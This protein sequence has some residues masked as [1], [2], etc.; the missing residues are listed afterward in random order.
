MT[1]D[2]GAD[3][4][5]VVGLA[6]RLL[7]SLHPEGPMSV[8]LLLGR[9][10][11]SLALEVPLP[12]DARLLGSALH[13]QRGRPTQMQALFDAWRDPQEGGAAYARQLAVSGWNPFAGFGGMHG[14]FVHG[15]LGMGRSFGAATLVLC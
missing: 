8:Q 4:D 12:Q 13:S 10:P 3:E 5:M 14:G 11:N 6:H 15:G 7:P 2:T 9:L 1:G